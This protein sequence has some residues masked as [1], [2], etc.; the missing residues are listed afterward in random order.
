[1]G[2]MGRRV[3]TLTLAA[4]LVGIG[5]V[6]VY[7]HWP[8]ELAALA[9]QPEGGGNEGKQAGGAV[10]LEIYIRRWQGI[11]PDVQVQVGPGRLG[12]IRGLETL[13]VTLSQGGRSQ[14]FELQRS[15]DGRY[16][17]PAPLLDLSAD[18]HAE[19]ARRIGLAERPSLGR[20]DAPVT[21]VE[22]SSFQCPFCRRLAPAVKQTMQ[23]PLGKEVRWV[24]KHFPLGSQAWSEPAAVAAECARSIGGDGK[25]WALHDLYFEQQETFTAE[26]HRERAVAWARGAGLPVKAFEGCL[27]SPAARKRVQE[28]LNEGRAIGVASTPTLVINGRV[29]PGA[30]SAEAL[31]GILEQELAYQRARERARAGS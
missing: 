10:P 8:F 30:A 4:M 16:L 2:A 23:G 28:D 25:F 20:T 27:G 19:I 5:A 6:V 22:Y 3:A 12:P 29:A 13:T 1:M 31:A 14:S 21:V 9:A 15:T 26:N 17:L 11:P 7:L 18:P 24:Y